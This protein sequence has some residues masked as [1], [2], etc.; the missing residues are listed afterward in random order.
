MAFGQA[1]GRPL[2]LGDILELTI[3]HNLVRLDGTLEY[4]GKTGTPP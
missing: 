1:A 3:E 2:P 4:N